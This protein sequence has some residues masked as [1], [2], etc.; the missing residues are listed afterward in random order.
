MTIEAVGKIW[1]DQY[2]AQLTAHSANRHH[3]TRTIPLSPHHT[4]PHIKIMKMKSFVSDLSE[5]QNEDLQLV[6][7][8]WRD[9]ILLVVVT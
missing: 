1:C 3:S 5:I 8:A 9:S 4:P 6:V 7:K 2:K